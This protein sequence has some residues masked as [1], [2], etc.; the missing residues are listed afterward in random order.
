MVCKILSLGETFIPASMGN[1][2]ESDPVKFH[3]TFL[4]VADRSELGNFLVP[5]DV[6]KKSVRMKFDMKDAFIRSVKKI[7]NLTV[8][9]DGET[10]D[11]TSASEFADLPGFD[12]MYHEVCLRIKE[13][14]EI[15]KKS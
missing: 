13:N 4:T 3:L 5:I 11:I 14:T 1:D 7:D 8:E 10:K 9:I 2:K 12:E 6:T 15:Q